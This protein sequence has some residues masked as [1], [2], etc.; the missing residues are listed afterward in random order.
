MAEVIQCPA[1]L[2]WLNLEM[3]EAIQEGAL[4]DT[5]LYR[6]GKCGAI[7]TEYG[8]VVAVRGNTDE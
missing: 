5:L 3:R 6:C 8:D 4:G 7:F 1:C 2:M